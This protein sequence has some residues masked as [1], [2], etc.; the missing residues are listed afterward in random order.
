MKNDS[1]IQVIILCNNFSN[2]FNILIVQKEKNVNKYVKKCRRLSLQKK[3]FVLS[4]E[5]KPKKK[6]S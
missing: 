4:F 3:F 5:K 2:I 6:I 1:A